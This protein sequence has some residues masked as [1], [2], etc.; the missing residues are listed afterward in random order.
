MQKY[1]KQKSNLLTNV[2]VKLCAQQDTK[3]KKNKCNT[4]GILTST[5]IYLGAPAP[6]PCHNHSVSHWMPACMQ[7]TFFALPAYA[8]NKQNRDKRSLAS[9]N[10]KLHCNTLAKENACC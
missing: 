5:M 4:K 1:R 3:K 9:G 7:P 10:N 8:I 6:T 2:A